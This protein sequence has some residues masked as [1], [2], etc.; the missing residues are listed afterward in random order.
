MMLVARRGVFPAATVMMLLLTKGF[1][2]GTPT[3]CNNGVVSVLNEVV[4]EAR[5]EGGEGYG[6]D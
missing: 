1:V 4:T 6:I 3:S 2:L 5:S